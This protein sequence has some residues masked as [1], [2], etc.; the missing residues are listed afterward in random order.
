MTRRCFVFEV[1]RRFLGELRYF[2]LVIGLSVTGFLFLLLKTIL[3]F[4]NL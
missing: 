1:G 3:V 2:L 4:F